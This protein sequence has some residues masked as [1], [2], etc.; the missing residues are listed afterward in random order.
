[1]NMPTNA[2]ASKPFRF[3][4]TGMR[5]VNLTAV[6][7]LG[8]ASVDSPGWLCRCDCGSEVILEGYLLRSG[9]S[10]SCGC[11]RIKS[12]T[13]HGMHRSLEYK[14]WSGMK[15]RCHNPKDHGY[16]DYGGRGIVVCD[17]W[18]YSFT[19][20]FKDMGVKPS[21]KHSI[22]RKNNNG[23]YEPGNCVWATWQDQQN[24]RRSSRIITLGGESL[25]VAEWARKNGMA[26][27]T[28]E[29]RIQHQGWDPAKALTTP[30]R[31][32]QQKQKPN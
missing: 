32:K 4:L 18:R 20:F 23:N 16:P 29:S 13:K 15:S 8:R 26:Y 27:V 5:F 24:N 22:E 19:N 7:Y 17:R 11:R 14:T 12:V 9:I 6:R 21:A 31:Q 28:L 3:D 30:V 10:K 25:T 1:M 2:V